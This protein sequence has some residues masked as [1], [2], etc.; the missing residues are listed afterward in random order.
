MAF[1][2]F[3][4]LWILWASCICD[5]VSVINLEIFL[6]IFI[7]NVFCT[8]LLSSSSNTQLCVLTPFEIV[9][10]FWDA[11]LY[12]YSVWDV[13]VCLSQAQQF[14]HW[15][16]WAYCWVNRRYSLFLLPFVDILDFHLICFLRFY[17]SHLT[18]PNFSFIFLLFAIRNIYTLILVILCSLLIITVC[19]IS[20]SGLVAFFVSSY[21]DYSCLSQTLQFFLLKVY[22]DV[23]RNRKCGK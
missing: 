6:A 7:S 16:C 20:E 1:L 17:I 11:L 13:S 4:L 15:S 21:C 8:I 23:L 19:V 14:F 3:V 22:Y 5:F 18:L 12:F 9:T 10:L 2:L